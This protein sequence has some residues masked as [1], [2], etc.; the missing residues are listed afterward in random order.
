MNEQLLQIEK[1]VR[2]LVAALQELQQTQHQLQLENKILRA[3]QK[4]L[5]GEIGELTL[6]FSNLQGALALQGRDGSESA[7]GVF[8]LLDQFLPALEQCMQRIQ[9]AAR[10]DV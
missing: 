9:D 3:E 4:A 8:E 10:D 7:S 2:Q 1:K 5:R 6:I